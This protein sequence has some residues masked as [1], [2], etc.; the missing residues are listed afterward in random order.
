MIDW[1][2]YR[3]LGCV[4]LIETTW[5]SSLLSCAGQR[6]KVIALNSSFLSFFSLFFI[7]WLTDDHHKNKKQHKPKWNFESID[8]NCIV[9]LYAWSERK[10]ISG[11]GLAFC[12]SNAVHSES[13]KSIWFSLLSVVS[14]NWTH[15][16]TSD[17]RECDWCV[18]RICTQH[19][20]H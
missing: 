5:S 17:W 7:E 12:T 19:I 14:F 15:S 4:G 2:K 3:K 20:D 6:W 16:W 13:S 18:T 9:Y 11:S 8:R 1:D 10:V